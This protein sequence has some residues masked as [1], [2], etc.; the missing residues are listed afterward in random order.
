MAN[1]QDGMIFN[2]QRWSIHDGPGVRTLVFFKGCPLE[3]RWCCNP[4]SQTGA[5]EILIR[6]DECTDCGCCLPVCPEGIAMTASEGGM[7]DRDLCVACGRCVQACPT[8]AR[9]FTG[10][11]VTL[12]QVLS[13]VRRDAAFYR[14]SGGGVTLSGG[15]ALA[16]PEFAGALIDGCRALGIDVVTETCGCFDWTKAFEIIEKSELIYLDLKHMDSAQHQRLTGVGNELILKNAVRIAETNTPLIVRIPVIPTLNDSIENISNTAEFVY[17]NL[18]SAREI[19]L[20]PYHRLGLNKYA[21]L[22]REYELTSIEP[23]DEV[24]LARLKQ[25]VKRPA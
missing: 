12:N 16:Q 2:I 5:T 15:E 23:P 17:Q 25:M 11:K 4:E 18:P 21:S 6:A 8:G 19:E 9:A 22:G 20:M 10:Q 14:A 1:E 3:C 7:T 13:I 24:R